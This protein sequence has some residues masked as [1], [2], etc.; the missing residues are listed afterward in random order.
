MHK[1]IFWYAPKCCE[2]NLKDDDVDVDVDDEPKK[3]EVTYPKV[4]GENLKSPTPRQ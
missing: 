1:H 2:H 4:V 3:S